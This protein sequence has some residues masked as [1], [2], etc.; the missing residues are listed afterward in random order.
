MAR[1]R[2]Y[3]FMLPWLGGSIVCSIPVSLFGFWPGL[4]LCIAAGLLANWL[5][6]T[7]LEKYWMPRP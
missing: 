6:D 5:F 1:R 2:F 4:G 3:L 7:L